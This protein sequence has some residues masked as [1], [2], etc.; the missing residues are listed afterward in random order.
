MTRRRYTP[1]PY[2]GIAQR[3][4]GANPR[5]ALWAGMGMGKTVST[6]TFIDQCIR[7]M[8]E[9]EP[10]LVAAPLRV[11]RGTW[12]NEVAKWDHLSGLSVVPILGTTAER[13]AAV[14]RVLRGNDPIATI[15]YDNLPWLLE[16]LDRTGK[17]HLWPFRR[18]VADESTRLKSFRTKQGGK[19][20]AALNKLMLH[21]THDV[22]E[23]TGTP[24]PNGL[25]DLWGQVYFLDQGQRL[26]RTFSAFKERWFQASYESGGDGHIA[27]RPVSWAQD[28]I[29]ERLRDICLTLDPRDWFDVKKPVVNPIYV[30]LPKSVRAKYRELE[31]DFFTQIRDHDIEAVNSASKSLKLLQLASGA[32][33]VDPAADSDNHPRSRQWIEVHDEKLDALESV[34]NEAAGMPII[35]AYHF[36]SDIARIKA[37]FGERARLIESVKDEDDFKAGKIG[38]GIAHP[39][40]LGH[41]VDGF[42]EV[43]NII[44]FFS[45]WWALETHDQIIERVGP[46]RQLQAGKD[47]PVFVHY[48][49]ARNTVDELVM[50]RHRSKRGVQDILLEAMK[51]KL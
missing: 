16:Y 34:V 25:I 12:P 22:I 29:Q 10:T 26:G 2:Q 36:R 23:L 41:G 44:V 20:A 51:G 14:A 17:R 9:S 35:V 8:G 37:R 13:E 40:S 18:V 49:V 4:F 1:H 27:V 5:S 32:V 11:A 42:Q 15:N 33:Y 46:V 31:R 39:A 7:L 47:R 6:L 50:L 3:F 38:I 30:D 43:T 28:E 45:H 19:R 48:I 21:Y 24:S